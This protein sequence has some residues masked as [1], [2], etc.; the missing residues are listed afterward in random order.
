[1]KTAYRSMAL[2]FHLDKNIGLD[3]PKMMSMINEAEDVLE[4]ILCTN[5]ASR[6]EE[7][8][9]AA[10]NTIL[11]SSDDNYDSETSNTS[12]EPA[13]SSNKASTLPAKHTNDNEET[14]L[15]KTH[16]RPWTSN[17]EVL[18]TIKKL[19]FKCGGDERYEQLYIFPSKWIDLLKYENIGDGIYENLQ[20]ACCTPLEFFVEENF[21]N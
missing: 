11:L 4:G 13:T 18:E 12:S 15:K 5:D 20:N 8:V 16:P 10:E 19:Y 7:R 17:K 6:V 1:M 14:P 3:T 2:R 9:R 21:D